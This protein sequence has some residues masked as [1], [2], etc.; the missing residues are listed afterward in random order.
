[1]SWDTE[2]GAS[3]C[4][5]E[6]KDQR[7]SQLTLVRRK[8]R[9]IGNS[10]FSVHMSFLKA[11]P[12]PIYSTATGDTRSSL[13]F[14]RKKIHVDINRTGEGSY[15]QEINRTEKIHV[16]LPRPRQAAGVDDAFFA[17]DD[18]VV[19]FV[20]NE[21]PGDH[22]NLSGQ[23]LGDTVATVFLV[24]TC[25]FNTYLLSLGR[26]GLD[27]NIPNGLVQILD[28][29]VAE[30]SVRADGDELEVTIELC[31]LAKTIRSRRGPPVARN[32]LN[33]IPT[34]PKGHGNV[35]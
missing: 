6:Y 10:P 9:R 30:T 12:S 3:L 26:I 7:H 31:Q 15:T 22:G 17:A 24:A 14:H 19:D 34:S 11:T 27:V 5:S 33:N 18:E 13:M 29:P 2:R 16:S 25:N 23:A 21:R 28:I 4:C 32:W 8:L 20:R 35:S 1:M